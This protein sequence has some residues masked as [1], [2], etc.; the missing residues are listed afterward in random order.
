MPKCQY[1]YRLE[2][3]VCQMCKDRPDG[4]SVRFEEGRGLPIASVYL[5][6]D[7]VVAIVPHSSS[8]YGG[9]LDGEHVCKIC[10][11]LHVD[12]DPWDRLNQSEQQEENLR[13]AGR[14]RNERRQA[15]EANGAGG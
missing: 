8:M 15:A 5:R 4:W 11:T 10:F 7:G 12:E 2:V 1:P 14:R 13:K 6:A 9:V 3:L